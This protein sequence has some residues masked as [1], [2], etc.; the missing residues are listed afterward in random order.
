MLSRVSLTK[1]SQGRIN[2]SYI[3]EQ[4]RKKFYQF[5][6]QFKNEKMLTQY[7]EYYDKNRV[8]VVRPVKEILTNPHHDLANMRRYL[9]YY[10][11]KRYY[12][13]RKRRTKVFVDVGSSARLYNSCITDI[14]LRPILDSTDQERIA[15]YEFN[16]FTRLL[17]LTF[18]QFVS[19]VGKDI[20]KCFFNFTD[21]LYYIDDSTL[22]EV[23]KYMN[24]EVYGTFTMHLV[25][26]DNYTIC[27]KEPLG[28]VEIGYDKLM[29]MQVIGNI[30]IYKHPNRFNE[31][32]NNNRIYIGQGDN[33]LEVSK[34][35]EFDYDKNFYICGTLKRVLNPE[36]SIV[37]SIRFDH[38]NENEELDEDI[39][40]MITK[41]VNITLTTRPDS[42]NNRLY[43]QVLNSNINLA[44][45]D[46]ELVR[47]FI[48]ITAD[49][50]RLVQKRFEDT[51]QFSNYSD[52]N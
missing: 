42:N 39:K 41:T 35:Y 22:L 45:I 20:N 37:S 13:N 19:K 6:S 15:N 11:I 34:E 43:T 36:T 48:Q 10:I 5:E 33:I 44:T 18:E 3:V 2:N 29:R 50:F 8:N 14:C 24:Y 26:Y 52:E 28:S 47:R 31:L 30:S 46:P 12:P 23:N 1:F 32:I 25:R 16:V 17:P 27:F 40:N 38:I 9:E 51:E 49:R 4:A 7:I 21:L